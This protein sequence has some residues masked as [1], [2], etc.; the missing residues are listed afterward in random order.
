MSSIEIESYHYI[1]SINLAKKQNHRQTLAFKFVF[2]RIHFFSVFKCIQCD[3]FF[4]LH[5]QSS[6]QLIVD[7]SFFYWHTKR[8]HSNSSWDL[9]N[10]L[11][12]YAIIRINKIQLYSMH[13]IYFLSF[14]LWFFFF[15]YSL[16]T[17]FVVARTNFHSS[18]WISYPWDLLPVAPIELSVWWHKTDFLKCYIFI[19]RR[20]WRAHYHTTHRIKSEMRIRFYKSKARETKERKRWRKRN[21]IIRK[22]DVDRFAD[23]ALC[24]WNQ[25]NIW[26]SCQLYASFGWVN[27]TIN[28][29]LFSWSVYFLPFLFF[30]LVFKFSFFF[31]IVLFRYS[32][33]WATRFCQIIDF[34]RMSVCAYTSAHPIGMRWY[35]EEEVVEKK[36]RVHNDDEDATTKDDVAANA[37]TIATQDNVHTHTT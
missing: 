22:V 28:S 3:Q 30:I 8:Q 23:C 10:S 9:W 35:R 16:D 11:C 31:W 17:F 34:M 1:N 6:K 37:M 36:K 4:K 5:P 12:F 19:W 21:W 29:H 24:M 14:F 33:W 18:S 15:M 27:F 2:R 7:S 26:K 32:I 20:T 25:M 13:R